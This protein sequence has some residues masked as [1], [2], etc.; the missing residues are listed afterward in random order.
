MKA[1]V[2]D[3]ETTGLIENTT[4]KNNK[5]PEIIEFYGCIVDISSKDTPPEHEVN[6]LIRPKRY[7]EADYK[8]AR[9]MIHPDLLQDQ[10]PFDRYALKIK[11]LIEMAPMVIAHNL[12]FDHEM[13]DIEMKR[14]GLSVAWP[15]G[16]CSIEATVYL[17]G[18]RLNLTALHEHLFGA[19]FPEAHRAKPDV[20][21][22]VRC[23]RLLHER[24][25]I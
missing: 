21:A 24:G 8:E 23:V 19:P 12:A 9:S 17:K 5:L 25:D 2:F 20:E 16:L 3:T 18:F 1:L 22:L 6:V 15:R 4:L 11:N 7:A 10:L 13:V 14:V